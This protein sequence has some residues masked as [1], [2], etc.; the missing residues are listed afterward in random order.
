MSFVQQGSQ[1]D[2]PVL[3]H[4]GHLVYVLHPTPELWTLN[5]PHRTQ[6][7]Y[8]TDIANITM[9]LELKPGSVCESGGLCPTP[10]CA[11]GPP[12]HGFH[13]Q[14]AEKVAEEFRER[15]GDIPSPWEAVQHDKIAMK[16]GTCVCSFSPCIEQVQKTCE[17]LAD[18]GFE[19]ISTLEVLLK[20]HA[21]APSCSPYQTLVLTGPWRSPPTPQSLAT[22]LF[23]KATMPPVEMAV[24]TGYLT[25]ATKPRV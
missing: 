9:M 24:H 17:A 7:L 20:V 18:D 16:R 4:N 22:P 12:A 11:H 19:A 14:H 25:F 15:R 3:W 5:L 10:S 2:M 21:C 8:T 1:T 6:I 13:Q 23:S